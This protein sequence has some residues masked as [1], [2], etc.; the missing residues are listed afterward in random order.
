MALITLQFKTECEKGL[1]TSGENNRKNKY[2]T[3][4]P[5]VEL[6][7]VDEKSDALTTVH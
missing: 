3:P 1:F 5:G 2:R 7:S 4:P 6:G